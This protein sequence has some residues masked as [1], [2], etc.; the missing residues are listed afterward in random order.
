VGRTWSRRREGTGGR[1][2]EWRGKQQEWRKRRG[3]EES[4]RDG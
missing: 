4:R 3:L 2:E 1:R